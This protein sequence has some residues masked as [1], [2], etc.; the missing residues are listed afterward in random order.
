MVIITRQ[1]Q[2]QQQPSL[3]PLTTADEQMTA[4]V[5]AVMNR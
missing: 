3:H 2:Q 5:S 1:Q 4:A